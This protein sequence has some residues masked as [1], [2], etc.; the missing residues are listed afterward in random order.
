M[1]AGEVLAE[2]HAADAA[3]LDA[4]EARLRAAVALSDEPPLAQPLMLE[5]L[6]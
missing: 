1:R 6:D 3:R 2:L 4:G 5:R